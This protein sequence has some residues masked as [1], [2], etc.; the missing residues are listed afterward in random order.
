MGL[1]AGGTR[2]RILS[3]V[4]TRHFATLSLVT[5]YLIH[6]LIYRVPKDTCQP[7][8]EADHLS[9]SSAEAKHS[10]SYKNTLPDLWA[11]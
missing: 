5:P 3:V 2:V 11:Q 10:C 8:H 9:Q 6:S 7:L 1:C 4:E